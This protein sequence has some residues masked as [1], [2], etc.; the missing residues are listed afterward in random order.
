MTSMPP[1]T[2]TGPAERITETTHSQPLSP[3][4]AGLATGFLNSWRTTPNATALI[5]DGCSWTYDEIL[6][7]ARRWAAALR[8]SHNSASRQVVGIL[9]DRG[10]TE[11]TAKLAA[12]LAGCIFVPL[13]PKFPVARLAEMINRAG[14]STLITDSDAAALVPAIV[15]AVP[16]EISV[17]LTDTK[18]KAL[19]HQIGSVVTDVVDLA[20]ADPLPLE[21]VA[22]PDMT[23]AAYIMFTSGSS[24]QPK[25]VPITHGNLRAF[26]AGAV[27]RHN[28]CPTDVFALT[29]DSTFDLSI[30]GPFVAWEVGAAAA[31]MSVADLSDPAGF[32]AQNAVTVWLSV[33]SVAKAA[34]AAGRL[35]PDAFPSLRFSFFCGEALPRRTAVA[36][37]TAASQ[38]VLVNMYGPTEATIFVTEFT[39]DPDTPLDLCVNDLVPIGQ[40]YKGHQ[41]VIIDEGGKPVTSSARGEL[42]IAGPQVFDGYLGAGS[43][44][45]SPFIILTGADGRPHKFYRTG[46]LCQWVN[47]HTLVYLARIDHQVKVSGYRIELG[48]VEAGLRRAGA[49]EAIAIPWPTDEPRG[50]VAA[51]TGKEPDLGKLASTLPPYMIPHTLHRVDAMPLN[52]NGKID[53]NKVT[54]NIKARSERGTHETPPSEESIRDLVAHAL[55]EATDDL[56]ANARLHHPASWDSLGHNAVIAALETRL[57]MQI[58]PEHDHQLR[59]VGGIMAFV[60]GRIDERSVDRSLRGQLVTESSITHTDVSTGVILYR[61]YSLTELVETS[62]YED[63]AYLILNGELPDATERQ[64]FR[65]DLARRRTPSL[66]AMRTLNECAVAGAHPLA[67]VTAAIAALGAELSGK[68]QGLHIQTEDEVRDA[69]L[70][71]IAQLPTLTS[72]YIRIRDGLNPIAPDPEL[73]QIANLLAMLDLPLT[74]QNERALTQDFIIHADNGP[75]ASTFA[76]MVANSAH[77]TV[78]AAVATAASVF[79][80][81]RHGYASET[82]YS[83]L[84]PMKDGSEVRDFV[85]QRLRAGELVD[86][87]GHAI[88]GR[89]GDPRL[90]PYRDIATTVATTEGNLIGLEKAMSMHDTAVARKNGAQPNYDLFGGLLYESLGL[91]VDISAPLH[92]SFRVVGWVAHIIEERVTCQPLVRPDARYVGPTVRSLSQANTSTPSIGGTS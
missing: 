18:G 11:H 51:I 42:C 69:G 37:Q 58:G 85:D 15:D 24:G 48:D 74:N 57:G 3:R 77:V 23:D 70:D 88:F 75:T 59:S 13:N 16:T 92:I 40:P 35:T 67:A 14:V 32:L 6:D 2:S 28:F 10:T 90:A 62:T 83:Q 9:A 8:R 82:A 5:H 53:R 64:A 61:G 45:Q 7:E 27:E 65:Q 76:C 17:L 31:T 29:F 41:A 89:S 20:A 25:G 21:T 87:I 72:A 12:L 22:E 33:P 80:G 73:S 26:V 1:T 36:W 71:L 55:G 34:H 79:S 81:A 43:A 63:V 66:I 39:W 46:D 30:F 54:A 78:H 84:M 60:N 4:F 68:R 44:T 91:P 52:P 19:R 56:P 50:L 49:T 86:G 47:E 38:S